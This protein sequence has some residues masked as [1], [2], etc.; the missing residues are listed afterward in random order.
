MKEIQEECT[1][2]G[3]FPVAGDCA[4]F[5]HC[6]AYG[7]GQFSKSNFICS[8][9]TVWDQKLL[10]CNYPSDEN[11]AAC[12]ALSTTKEPVNGKSHFIIRKSTAL[13]T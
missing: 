11:L 5:Y 13:L 4:K 2:A 9:G 7:N 6:T 8:P 3:Y 12:E 1:E 10:V